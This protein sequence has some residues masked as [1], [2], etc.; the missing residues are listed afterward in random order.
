M[1]IKKEK[2]PKHISLMDHLFVSPDYK[3]HTYL[4][5]PEQSVVR[6]EKG[7]PTLPS[8]SSHNLE[9]GSPV[10]LVDPPGYGTIRWIG[11][12][13]GM[14]QDIAGV[15]M[16]SCVVIFYTLAHYSIF[17]GAA[18]GSPYIVFKLTFSYGFMLRIYLYI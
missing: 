13:P 16:V 1:P 10:E 8:P 14:D 18:A 7:T 15:E 12:F 4:A 2:V 11:K 17:L 9:V 3:K 6:E 5:V